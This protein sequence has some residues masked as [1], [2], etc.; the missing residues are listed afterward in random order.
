[1]AT[2]IYFIFALLFNNTFINVSWSAWSCCKL[3]LIAC[4]LTLTRLQTL[5]EAM[6]ADE[7]SRAK[8]AF[9]EAVGI[10]TIYK[11]NSFLQDLSCCVLLWKFL[12]IWCKLTRDV[13]V[14]YCLIVPLQTK[15]WVVHIIS[16]HSVDF[17]WYELVLARE[18]FYF[19][20]YFLY[21]VYN[22]KLG[23]GKWKWG[24][25]KR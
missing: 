9:S 4:F 8:E 19:S 7:G 16:V 11:Q 5:N 15:F 2:C 1:M 18:F 25:C 21:Q 14:T 6:A 17:L 24:Y 23:P 3:I 20:Y 10:I 22:M 13:G 12:P